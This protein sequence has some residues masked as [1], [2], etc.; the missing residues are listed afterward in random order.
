[1]AAKVANAVYHATGRRIRDLPVTIDE[2]LW[3]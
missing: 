1:V 3:A 2:L